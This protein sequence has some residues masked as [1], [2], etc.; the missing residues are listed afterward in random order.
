MCIRDSCDS[1]R[2][3][4]DYAH[5]HLQA[6]LLLAGVLRE[7]GVIKVSPEDALASLSLIHI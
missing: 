3:G 2:A 7:F 5:I 6:H 1:V 4:T